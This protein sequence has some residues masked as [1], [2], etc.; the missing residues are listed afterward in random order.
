MT[1]TKLFFI[2][3]LGGAISRF[4]A[5]ILVP[6]Y[7]HVL[8]IAEYG[9]LE[10][11][12]ALHM[13][14]VILAG[15]QTESGVA[16]DYFE[17]KSKGRGKQLAWS[18]VAISVVGAIL[19]SVASYAASLF[20]L[21]PADLSTSTILLLLGLIL[22]V[23]LFGIQQAMLRFEGSPK[24]F[25]F[26]SFCDLTF[27][28]VFSVIFVAILHLGP[29]GALL[30]L[31]CGKLLGLAIAWT[32]TFGNP[33]HVRLD[34]KMILGLLNYGVPSIPAVFVNWLHNIGNR[35]ILA[36][37]L[38]LS[39]VA[40]AGVAIKVA[41]LYGFV[42]YS[43]R[44]AWEP[45]AISG[46]VQFRSDR[47]LYRRAQ[48]WYVLSMFFVAGIAVMLGPLIASLLAPPAYAN[49]AGIA[50][51]FGFGQ[52]WV[53]MTTMATIGIQGARRTSKLLPV[54][55]SGLLVNL[56]FLSFGSHI[57]G[58][59]AA[60]FGFLGGSVCSALVAHHLSNKLFDTQLSNKLVGSTAVA[61]LVFCTAWYQVILQFQESAQFSA[62]T[63]GTFGA[64]IG[65]LLLLQGTTLFYATSKSRL[66]EMLKA[67][68][69]HFYIAQ[70]KTD[71]QPLLVTAV[72]A[73]ASADLSLPYIATRLVRF[74]KY[75][76]TSHQVF[77]IN[78]DAKLLNTAYAV[79][80]FGEFGFCHCFNEASS[81]A[82]VECLPEFLSSDFAI[83]FWHRS[84]KGAQPGTVTIG[85][86]DG[87]ALLKIAFNPFGRPEVIFSGDTQPKLSDLNQTEVSAGWHHVLMQ[88][89]QGRLELFLDGAMHS[90]MS[91]RIL[92]YSPTR[93]LEVSNWL[94]EL[95]DV[96]LYSFTFPLEQV[97]R[98]AYEW[99]QVKP[100]NPVDPIVSFF[101]LEGNGLEATGRGS[102][103]ATH[104]VEPASD[105]FGNANRACTFNGRNAF[106]DLV[107]GLD[108]DPSAFAIGFWEKADRG[109]HMVALSIAWDKFTLDLAFNDRSAMSII[110]NS[111]PTDTLSIGVTG[112]LTDGA[113]HFVFVQRF[114]S[115]Q[116]VYVDGILRASAQ[117]SESASSSA[118]KVRLGR[119][120]DRPESS[121]CH[122]D[123]LL[124]D[125]Q[126]YA[127]SFTDEE[128][129]DL[130]GVDFLPSDGAGLLSFQDKVWM[131]GGRNPNNNPTANSEV[132]T[133]ADGGNWVLAS[134]APWEGRHTAGYLVFKDR[135]WIV[136]G[137]K[138]RGHYQ[139]DVW[140]SADGV[141]WDLITD[142][143][144]WAGR[145][146]HN[147]L[148]FQKRM[149]VL[150][151]QEIG[152]QKGKLVAFND[153]YSSSDGENWVL[154][155]KMANWSPRGMILGSVVHRGRMWIIGGGTCDFR[156]FNNDVWNSQDGV[157]WNLINES[158]PWTS[159]QYH[160]AVVFDDK[161]WV[162]AGN[163]YGNAGSNDVWYSSDGI[164]WTELAG[165]PW[166][167]R[168]AASV[169]VHGASIW[170]VG[171]SELCI[172]N[173]VWKL[174][175]AT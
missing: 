119:S 142:T 174:R 1:F 163:G 161:I 38:S 72:K 121:P 7:T 175:H 52:F 114:D 55:L 159:R 103:G 133:T 69:T 66:V 107:D 170:L 168:H 123:G 99:F 113:W 20:G 157:H 41:A 173:D 87:R 16:R 4:A 109:N 106:I 137:D 56:A 19:I 100:S 75:S 86:A 77:A 164:D 147:V 63:V 10:V 79:N 17:L 88:V 5:I 105:R 70:T 102:A 115:V 172:Y 23:Q 57:F 78:L 155:T 132:W 126:I 134:I 83:S 6:L 81:R 90:S 166:P 130:E 116:K 60:G 128:I 112:E 95:D 93:K 58:A 59:L 149:W 15:M 9:Q 80:R 45:F 49:S 24:Y 171:G 51:F 82:L 101:R 145:V 92:S 2:Y 89:R 120:S 118:A 85:C 53:G 158:A 14:T 29:D 84:T 42:V 111:V 148:V 11:L 43:Y 62:S 91:A 35:L 144:P 30:G 160:S 152:N 98:L 46:L 25:A 31:L 36:V 169:A 68:R 125:V 110:T 140:S 54:Y 153:V 154:E 39:E 33:W 64:G 21:I 162:I 67:I 136:G 26:V 34:Q 96:R 138:N 141:H 73:A 71:S 8:S 150:G 167:V 104:N 156:T 131:L 94:G 143:V 61:T 97:S 129:K 48:E 135:M 37:T 139:N 122:W 146:S 74:F 124:D 65:L 22:P 117:I 108:V 18:A 44:L 13:L 47:Q 50:V 28:A 27:S 32:R 40:M 12:L 76:G 165:T 3:G 151:G 127:H